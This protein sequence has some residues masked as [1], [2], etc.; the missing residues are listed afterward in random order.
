[1]LQCMLATVKFQ[2]CV[3][4]AAEAYVCNVQGLLQCAPEEI[5]AFAKKKGHPELLPA[6]AKAGMPLERRIVYSENLTVTGE[7]PSVSC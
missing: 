4:C 3:H 5:A 1:M 7:S 6:F 2:L